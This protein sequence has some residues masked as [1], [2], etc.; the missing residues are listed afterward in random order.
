MLVCYTLSDIPVK[1]EAAEFIVPPV[2][3]EEIPKECSELDLGRCGY[4]RIQSVRKL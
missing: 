4:T 3:I 1:V 2:I